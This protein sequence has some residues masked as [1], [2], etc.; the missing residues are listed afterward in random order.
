MP[1]AV[2]EDLD[3]VEIQEDDS[4]AIVAK[5]KDGAIGFDIADFGSDP[6]ASNPIGS[7]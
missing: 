1:V 7:D 6:I 2:E 4:N 3:A 5:T